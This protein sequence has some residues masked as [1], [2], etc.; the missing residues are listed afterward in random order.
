VPCKYWHRTLSICELDEIKLPFNIHSPLA[1]KSHIAEAGFIFIENFCPHKNL[2]DI[3]AFLGNV[4]DLENPILRLNKTTIHSLAPRHGSDAN[5]HSYS[6][7][8]GLGRFPPHTDLA[9]WAIPPRYL[10]LRC[11]VGTADVATQI[12]APEIL[13]AVFDP[14]LAQRALF[15]TKRPDQRGKVAILKMALDQ[16]PLA[17][18]W[19]SVFLSPLNSAARLATQHFSDIDEMRVLTCTKVFLKNK[20]DTLIIDNWHCMHGRSPVPRTSKDR[21]IDRVYLSEINNDNTII[22]TSLV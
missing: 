16:D 11:S 17:F 1:I 7:C 18:R 4:V 6:G 10:I 13:R 3:A 14:D 15:R 9:H 20:N 5:H 19:D 22:S 21:S 2:N 12:Y 8:Y